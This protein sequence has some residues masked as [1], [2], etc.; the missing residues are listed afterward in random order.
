MLKV[1]LLEGRSD[2]VLQKNIKKLIEEGYDPKQAAAI[3]YEKAGRARKDRAGNK[4][5]PPPRPKKEHRNV[6]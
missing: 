6:R 3:A 5:V 1:P 4:R 2:E